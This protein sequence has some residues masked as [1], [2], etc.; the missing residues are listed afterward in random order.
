[1]D[2]NKKIKKFYK[3]CIDK[4]YFQY[5]AETIIERKLIDQLIADL[6]FKHSSFRAFADAYN[7]QFA[8]DQNSRFMLERRNITSIFYCFELIKFYSEHKIDQHFESIIFK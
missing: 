7:Y 1:M 5:T 4:K 2:A 8:T 6:V 3:N